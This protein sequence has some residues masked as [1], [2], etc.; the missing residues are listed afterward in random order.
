MVIACVP[1][2]LLAGEDARTQMLGS[3]FGVTLAPE[4]PVGPRG[5]RAQA[6]V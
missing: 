6:S 2:P 1:V 5:T 4:C 3:L